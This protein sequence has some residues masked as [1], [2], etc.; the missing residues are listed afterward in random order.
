M[1]KRGLAFLLAAVLAFAPVLQVNA[2]EFSAMNMQQTEE[3]QVEEETA[4]LTERSEASVIMEEADSIVP[5]VSEVPEVTPGIV[6]EVSATPEAGVFPEESAS[7][8]ASEAPEASAFPEGS[9][10]PEASETPETSAFPEGSASPEVSE[11][12]EAELNIN[13]ELVTLLT[14]DFDLTASTT[15]ASGEGWTWKASTKTFTMNG[16]HST[17]RSDDNRKR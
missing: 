7:P 6:P 13:T 12:L 14:E 15:D 3:V 10:S 9:A 1:C 16:Y 2:A 4:K 11:T 8:E 5:K 17:G